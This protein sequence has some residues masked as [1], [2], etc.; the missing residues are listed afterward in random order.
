MSQDLK[1]HLLEYIGDNITN[2]TYETL[3]ELAVI[4]AVKQDKIYRDLFFSKTR[5]RFI[6]ELEYLKDE[7][8]YKIVWSLFKSEQITG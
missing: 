5:D 1:H 8:A 2:L 7:T 4:H 6:K 3:A